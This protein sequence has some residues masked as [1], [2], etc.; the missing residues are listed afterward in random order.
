MARLLV[1]DKARDDV[2][3]IAAYI[4][5]DRLD[6]A[7]RFVDDAEVAFDFLALWPSAG[8]RVEPS[9]VHIPDLRFWPIKRFRNYLVMYRPIPDGVEILRVIHGA[10]DMTRMVD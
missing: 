5:R 1:R 8:P 6:A 3:A 4:A 9:P 2:Y 7:L 10:Q